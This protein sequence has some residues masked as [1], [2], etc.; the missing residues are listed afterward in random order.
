[1]STHYKLVL[2]L[3][4]ATLVAGMTMAQNAANWNMNSSLTASS[5]S[6]GVSV[7]PI[8]L[9]NPSITGS[10]NG[11]SEYYGE[12]GWPTGA[13][14][15]HA[16]FQ[17]SVNANSGY[18]L[19]FNSVTLVMRRSNTGTPAGSG[20]T[21]W[22]LRSSLDNYVSDIS[23]G[24]MTDAYATYAVS[25]PAAFH[26][27]PSAVI[28]RMY[29][30][31]TTVSPG[32]SSRFVFDNI[33]VQGHATAGILA[34]QSIRL[35]ATTTPT[36]SVAL[37]YDPTG[38]A[39]GTIFGVQRSVNGVDFS[40]V[41]QTKATADAQVWNYEDITL[42]DAPGLFYRISAAQ[43]GGIVYMSPVV[44]VKLSMQSGMKISA[45]IPQGTGA[46]VK[47]L[48]QLPSN[49]EYRLMVSS[50]DG[51][52]L[53]QK[54]ISGETGSLAADIPFGS[55]PHGVYILTLAS[56][57]AGQRISKQFIL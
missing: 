3:S 7:S 46:S 19:V 50:S 31:S 53:A 25:L 48:L 49:G 35:D 39:A 9:G 17:F 21:Q 30:Y 51:R 10:F 43:P 28:F 6:T 40:T 47:A 11:G 27:I 56:A 41:Y 57:N 1:M 15:T 33:S 8:T 36:N 52:P 12:G 4:L 37:K 44:S 14:D 26:A 32:G 23:T 20:P 5:T 18:Y 42:P 29:G 22:S 38:F 2:L 55:Y 34:E 13:L 24:S 45:V 16:Y 54:M